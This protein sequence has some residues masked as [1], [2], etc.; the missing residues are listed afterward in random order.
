MLSLHLS[1]RIVLLALLLALATT[2][3]VIV[4]DVA[5]LAL[6]LR[7]DLTLARVRTVCRHSVAAVLMVAVIAHAHGIVRQISVRTRCNDTLF[8]PRSAICGPFHLLLGHAFKRHR[9]AA[10]GRGAS[11]LLVLAA[12][13]VAATN[14]FDRGHLCILLLW[15]FEAAK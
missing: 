4:I 11:W 3:L 5:A 9:G 10:G 1:L 7:V 12:G 15:C 8:A 13:S 6:A 2:H 14:Y